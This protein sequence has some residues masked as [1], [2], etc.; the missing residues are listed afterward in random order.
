[1]AK[2]L[3]IGGSGSGKSE[4]AERLCLF[5]AGKQED[6][7]YIATM[8][9][10]GKDAQQRI[11]RHRDLRAG[12]G[13]QTLEY[14]CDFTSRP[15]PRGTVLLECLGNLVA[16]EFFSEKESSDTAEARVRADVEA[17][18][19][20]C[21]NL[22]VVT[23]DIFADGVSYDQK[24]REYVSLLGRTNELLAKRF[25]QVIEVVCGIPLWHKGEALE[26]I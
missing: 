20:S 2:I 25:D 17:L 4:I 18:E 9:A 19:K 24:T 6:L 21:S 23:N 10:F 3:I 12:K 11:K 1:M 14:A 7:S 5:Y 15:L 22:I 16:N 8:V 13:F 26:R